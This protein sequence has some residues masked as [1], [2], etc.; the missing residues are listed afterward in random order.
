MSVSMRISVQSTTGRSSDRRL[1]IRLASSVFLWPLRAGENQNQ[2]RLV[3][4]QSVSQHSFLDLLGSVVL[5][6]DMV[7][8]FEE[9]HHLPG[10]RTLQHSRGLMADV[11]SFP[12][13]ILLQEV[14]VPA[15]SFS[16]LS[17]TL[18][19]VKNLVPIRGVSD[20]HWRCLDVVLPQVLRNIVR[21]CSP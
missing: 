17:G 6:D 19:L 5:S 7:W 10:P 11:P 18:F 13:T 21:V 14:E 4:E 1:P 3:L 16:H 15:Q 9:W 8:Y 2:R 20:A 12:K